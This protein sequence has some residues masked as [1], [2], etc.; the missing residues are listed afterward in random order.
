MRLRTRPNHAEHHA[1]AARG[2]ICSFAEA[3]GKPG[4]ALPSVP[5]GT[6][7][8]TTS[9]RRVFSQRIQ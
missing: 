9:R 6:I 2:Y 8:L 1:P 7:Q 3:C 4:L 5:A